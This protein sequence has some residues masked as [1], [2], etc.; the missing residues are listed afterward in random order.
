M[1]SQDTHKRQ[2]ESNRCRNTHLITFVNTTA[3][4]L[5][6]LKMSITYTEHIY[7]YK[8]YLHHLFFPMCPNSRTLGFRLHELQELHEPLEPDGWQ[9]R[10]FTKI[11]KEGD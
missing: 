11:P 10:A 3:N 9:T 2:C 5:T 8:I 4:T 7:I 6:S 1:H